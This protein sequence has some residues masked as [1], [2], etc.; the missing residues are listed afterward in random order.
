MKISDR[1]F[2]AGHNG[3]VGSSI[4][5]E[6]KKQGF[7]NIV[8][9]N[10]SQLDLRNQ[11]EVNNFFQNESI[12]Y[13][14]IAAA[15]VGGIQKNAAEPAEFIYDN[16]SIQTNLIHGAYIAK[17][18]KLLFLGSSCIYPKFARQPIKEEYL[19]TDTLEPTNEAYAI[20]KIA[21]LKMCEYYKKQWGFNAISAMPCSLYGVGDYFEPEKSHVI[22]GI[23]D[24]IY[25]AK[26]KNDNNVVLWG[27]GTP[28]REFL[29]VDDLANA[30]VFLMNNYDEVDFINVGST[31]ELSIKELAEIIKNKL[32]FSGE[33]IWDTTKPNGTPRKK[34]DTEKLNKLGWNQTISFD[35]GIERTIQWYLKTMK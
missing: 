22:G 26:I 14:F 2:V 20:A 19:L 28:L 8:T 23:I 16:L 35:D 5:R 27:D 18:K 17:V 3:L 1:V 32:D 13:V 11:Q 4:V 12:D 34:M 33:I 7:T 31:V 30:C 21:G 9:K 25:K 24:K 15:K 6:L 10:K 29:Y